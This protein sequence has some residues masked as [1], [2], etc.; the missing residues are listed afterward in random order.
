MKSNCW[1]LWILVGILC[2]CNSRP[3]VVLIKQF[4][5]GIRYEEFTDLNSGIRALTQTNT[6]DGSR[7]FVIPGNVVWCEARDGFIIGEK[8]PQKK[9]ADW[10]HDDWEKREG[11]FLLMPSKLNPNAASDEE[12]LREAVDWFE[13]QAELTNAVQSKLGQ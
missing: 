4:E 5:N 12:V 11:F 8:R 13:T 2:A 7:D 6:K 10:M 3:A 1:I 9:P